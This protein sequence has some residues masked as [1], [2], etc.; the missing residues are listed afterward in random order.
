MVRTPVGEASLTIN[1]VDPG[2]PPLPFV[3]ILVSELLAI[4]FYLW[5]E[6]GFKPQIQSLLR[7]FWRWYR[8]TARNIMDWRLRTVPALR[9]YNHDYVTRHPVLVRF[10]AMLRDDDIEFRTAALRAIA[11]GAVE[12]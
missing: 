2:L 5:T 6:T 3:F 9:R 7:G 11:V 1:A 12:A 8:K 4:P 10:V